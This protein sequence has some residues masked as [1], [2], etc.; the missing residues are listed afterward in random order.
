MVD[1]TT[2]RP[3]WQVKAEY[4][5]F[6][7]F[8]A[9]VSGREDNAEPGR[10]KRQTMVYAAGFAWVRLIE[11]QG[12]WFNMFQD[13]VTLTDCGGPLVW[14][15]AQQP[16]L[17]AMQARYGGCWSEASG[18][19]YLGEQYD[20]LAWGVHWG[21]E[22]AQAGGADEWAQA[23]RY[24]WET[25]ELDQALQAV[26]MQAPELDLVQ[27]YERVWPAWW[28]SLP[29]NEAVGERWKKMPVAA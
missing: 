16:Q 15:D 10:G 21:Q 14:G 19:A 9:D 18:E 5:D 11:S 3:F 24:I 20:G 25:A 6:A 29:G 12:R 2:E 26:W 28:A 23:W 4:A 13:L 8:L 27:A 7:A 22:H 1:L 17:A